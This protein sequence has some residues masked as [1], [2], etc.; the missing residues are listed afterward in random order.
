MNDMLKEEDFKK[1]ILLL[2]LR[3]QQAEVMRVWICAAN[4]ETWLTS[5]ILAI[6]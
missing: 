1:C 4:E 5:H 3:Q 6:S 2:L